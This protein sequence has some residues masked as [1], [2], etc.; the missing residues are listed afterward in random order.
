MRGTRMSDLPH[1]EFPDSSADALLGVRI[2]DDDGVET[3]DLNPY[4]PLVDSDGHL[5]PGALFMAADLSLGRALSLRTQVGSFAITSHLHLE[6]VN[7]LIPLEMVVTCRAD[8][9]AIDSLSGLA[10]GEL[11]SPYGCVAIASGRFQVLPHG[12][13]GL[14]AVDGRPSVVDHVDLA[15]EA[16]QG[17]RD[18]DEILGIDLVTCNATEAQF[19]VAGGA[20]LANDRGGVHGGVGGLI[21]ERCASIA[22]NRWLGGPGLWRAT[23]LRV[24]FARPMLAVGGQ[25]T[26]IT[27]LRRAGRRTA[28]TSTTVYA[29]GRP[30][31]M[32][33]AIHSFIPLKGR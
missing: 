19:A 27:S 16:S 26:A 9:V 20:Q 18:V 4:P 32:G 12:H 5:P 23:E 6:L 8:V 22:V 24:F 15:P 29:Q 7:P 2:G 28:L 13:R 31:V 3:V 1:G 17:P 11:S 30:S 14:D 25:I 33:D 21:T 10:R